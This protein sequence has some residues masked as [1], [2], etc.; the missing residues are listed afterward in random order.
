MPL[1]RVCSLDDRSY[2]AESLTPSSPANCLLSHIFLAQALRVDVISSPGTSRFFST[3]SVAIDLTFQVTNE[4][5][6][7][8]AS[9]PPATAIE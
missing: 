5:F 4:D 6:A 7:L 9:V 1:H 8:C 3:A 2:I